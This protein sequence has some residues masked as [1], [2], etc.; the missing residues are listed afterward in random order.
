M[1]NSNVFAVKSGQE[2]LLLEDVSHVAVENGTVKLRTLFGEPMT[3]EGRIKEIDLIK[4]RI[5]LV[6]N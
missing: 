4:N 5:I 2:E 6:T 1:C 3:V